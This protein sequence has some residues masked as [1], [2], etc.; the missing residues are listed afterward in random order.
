MTGPSQKD[1][2]PHPL[3][4]PPQKREEEAF[5]RREKNS[6]RKSWTKTLNHDRNERRGKGEKRR[7][8]QKRR[9]SS[10]KPSSFLFPISSSTSPPLLP[11]LRLLVAVCNIGTVELWYTA[12]NSFT[13]CTSLV[14]L[15]YVQELLYSHIGKKIIIV[16]IQRFYCISW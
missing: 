8:V 5:W 1:F 13:Y 4:P 7:W 16:N 9:K 3:P 6:C 11:P 2:M 15:L 10:M 12:T 14:S